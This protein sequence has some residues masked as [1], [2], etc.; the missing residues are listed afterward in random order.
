VTAATVRRPADVWERTVRDEP[1]PARDWDELDLAPS[2]PLEDVPPASPPPPRRAWVPFALLGGA[3]FVLGFA[4]LV[5][6]GLPRGGAEAQPTRL[7]PLPIVVEETP[8][9]IPTPTPA[10][11]I[12]L[13]ATP[14]APPATLT[15]TPL[16][17]PPPTLASPIPAEPRTALSARSR[18]GSAA[19]VA[20]P[21]TTQAADEGPGFGILRIELEPAAEIS[22]DGQ[23]VGTHARHDALLEQGTH[24]VTLHF[25]G[26]TPFDRTVELRAGESVRLALQLD[27][28]AP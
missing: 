14:I 22:I 16:P 28:A 8:A 26:R 20:A 21:P 12:A 17:T 19:P 15:P 2:V 9:A 27:V 3:V 10:A 13:T 4:G 11:P 24:T 23:S 7:D 1:R 6:L 5:V 25:P 18:P